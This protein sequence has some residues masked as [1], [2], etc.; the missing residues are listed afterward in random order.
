MIKLQF[1][2]HISKPDEEN[3]QMEYQF[4]LITSDVERIGQAKRKIAGQCY[5]G[6]PYAEYQAVPFLIRIVKHNSDLKSEMYS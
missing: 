1:N 2:R 3:S 5:R 4:I 6:N